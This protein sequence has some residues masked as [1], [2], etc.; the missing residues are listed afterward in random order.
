MKKNNISCLNE[1]G[2]LFY[3]RI[4]DRIDGWE[5]KSIRLLSWR[6]ILRLEK[7]HR[8]RER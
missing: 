1:I 7:K 4:L 5:R 8:G 2:K 6:K 3:D